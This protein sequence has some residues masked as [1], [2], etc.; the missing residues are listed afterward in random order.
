MT[1]DPACRLCGAA[2]RTTLLDLGSM[3][4]ANALLDGAAD[5]ATEHTLPLRALVCD[6]C[7]LVQVPENLSQADIFTE[8][9]YFSSYS[10]TFLD[11]ARRFA[12]RVCRELGLGPGSLVVEAASNDGY[13]LRHFQE[14]GV[15]VLGIEPARNVARVAIAAGVPTDPRFLTGAVGEEHGPRADLVVANNVLGHVPDVHDFVGGLAALV[16]P[17]GVVAIEFHHVLALLQGLQFDT[18][19]HEHRSYFSLATAC[20]ALATAD[21]AVFDVEAIP[22]HGGS[23][24]VWAAPSAAGRSPTPAVAEMTAREHAAGLDGA[25]VYAAFARRAH[26]CRDAL[27]AFLDDAAR[28]GRTV[29]AYG[30]AA[31]GATLLNWVGA[32]PQT[33]R[34]VADRN[35]HKQGRLMPGT[36]IPVVPPSR[37]AQLRP[38]HVLVLPWNLADEITAQLAEIRGWGGTFVI[39]VPEPTVRAA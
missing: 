21:L 28:A 16:R 36:H 25:E 24:R 13:L 34:C 37:L 12:L 10:D 18:I 11:H 4:P 38:D 22:T 39:P 6:D 35:P 31:K 14:L 8:Y 33:I 17:G 7:R 5:A 26:T 30:A 23:L 2:L 9:A 32:T 19:Y 3:P 1:S 20:R 29:A 27:R 15:R